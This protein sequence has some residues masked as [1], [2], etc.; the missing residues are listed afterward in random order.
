MR[1]ERREE[2]PLKADPEI[3]RSCELTPNVTCAKELQPSKHW[4]SKLST[5]GGI[6]IDLNDEPQGL[7][8]AACM[9]VKARQR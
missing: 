3:T 5:E 4:D 9:D 7:K 2:H 6:S 8:S 1:K